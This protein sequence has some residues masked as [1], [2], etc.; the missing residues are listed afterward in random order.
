MKGKI[1]ARTRK[2]PLVYVVDD[3]PIIASSLTTILRLK[4]YDALAFTDPIKAEEAALIE[5]PDLLISDVMMPGLSGLE[6]A[7][8][9]QDA[10][11]DCKVL[12]FSGQAATS[13][14]LESAH[15][16]GHRFDLLAKPVSPGDLLK[17]IE[18][19]MKYEA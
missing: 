1:M 18:R 16:C 3:E 15:T 4:G 9:V 12:L 10:C 7:I 17:E 2:L 6:L 19:T 11:P 14:L 13:S 8:N 5:S